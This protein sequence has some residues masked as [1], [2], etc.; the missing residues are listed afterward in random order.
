[1]IKRRSQVL[2]VWFLV[3]DLLLT[4]SAWVGAYYLRFHSGWVPVRKAAPEPALCWQN[5]P[6]VV[7]LAAVSYHLTGQYSI[8]RLRRLREEVVGV[9]KGTALL[10][11]LRK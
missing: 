5:L 1:M 10:S 6:L 11:L 9:L 4:A 3:C 7:L 8:H 2:C